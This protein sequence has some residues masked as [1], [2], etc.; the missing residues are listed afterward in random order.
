LQNRTVD[1]Q[2]EGKLR[3]AAKD[4]P[5]MFLGE[6]AEMF[7]CL[8]QSAHAMLKTLGITRKKHLAYSE[9]SAEE[10]ERFAA[11]VKK[12]P[13]GKRVCVDE[14]G[15]RERPQR[16]FGCAPRGLKVAGAKPGKRFW[17]VNVIGV[18]CAALHLCVERYMH[19]A[20]SAFFEGWFE[21]RLLKA[22]PWGEG[23]AAIMDNASFHRRKVLRRLAR[24]KAR[25]LFLPPYSPDCNRI[26]KSRANMKRFLR[27]CLDK[28]ASVESAVHAR[29]A[30]S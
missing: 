15:I 6:L 22:M 21:N 5:D 13:Q 19:S 17:R 16:E 2:A 12:I 29:F 30:V 23:H 28:F 9:T 27:G 26:E 8:P 25:L 20:D 4:K 10:R 7:G 14:S 11:H 3:Q 24:G 1:K 18:L